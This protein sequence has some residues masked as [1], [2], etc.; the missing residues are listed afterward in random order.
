MAVE[1]DSSRKAVTIK[2]DKD[3]IVGDLVDITVEHVADGDLTTRQLLPNDG[4][5]VI[6]YPVEFNGIS[7]ITVEGRRG[8]TEIGEIVTAQGMRAEDLLAKMA[9]DPPEEGEIE[10]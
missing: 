3:A 5:A 7:H 2:W 1:K 8:E 10:V 6:T 4:Q 9:A